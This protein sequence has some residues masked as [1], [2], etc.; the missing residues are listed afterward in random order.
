[1]H[2][3]VNHRIYTIK[4]YCIHT[5]VMHRWWMWI[6]CFRLVSFIKSIYYIDCTEPVGRPSFSQRKQ[7]FFLNQHEFHSAI[8]HKGCTDNYLVVWTMTLLIYSQSKWQ[9]FCFYFLLLLRFAVCVGY[10]DWGGK[11]GQSTVMYVMSADGSVDWMRMRVDN[12]KERMDSDMNMPE[13]SA[14]RLVNQLESSVRLWWLAQCHRRLIIHNF[15]TE[16]WS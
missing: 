12:G 8:A 15:P 16:N 7:F 1:M 6:L 3:T 9:E 13:E 11:G 2:S 5:R 10:T 4:L 14:N